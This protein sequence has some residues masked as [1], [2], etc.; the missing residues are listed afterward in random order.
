[1]QN[2]APHNL[3]DAYLNHVN[4]SSAHISRLITLLDYLYVDN[5]PRQNRNHTHIT[6]I[7]NLLTNQEASLS[8]LINS[9]SNSSIPPVTR[10]SRY[11]RPY[12]TSRPRSITRPPPPATPPART[13]T[14]PR[15]ATRRHTRSSRLSEDEQIYSTARVTRVTPQRATQILQFR[16]VESPLNTT[17]PITAEALPDEVM[18]IIGCGHLFSPPH[19]RRWLND[20][21]TQ[22]PLC[23]YNIDLVSLI[24][25]FLQNMESF[26]SADISAN[27][28]VE[29][30]V[31][32]QPLYIPNT[33]PNE[34]NE[35]NN[36]N[37]ENNNENNETDTDHSTDNSLQQ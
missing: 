32:L 30:L 20:G 5:I 21:H 13:R 18:Q 25:D 8:Q 28:L 12:R 6:Q 35:N 34:N 31:E 14:P 3:E 19:L 7:L 11:S 17:C 27:F 10:S 26:G 16:D 29:T 22:C 15:S 1:M 2:R 33:I 4:S 9:H 23:R 24:T 37:N 36:E